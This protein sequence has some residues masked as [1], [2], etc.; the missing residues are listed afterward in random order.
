[1]EQ[2]SIM[3]AIKQVCA[4]KGLSVNDVMQTIETA[5]AAAYR[6]D[7]GN[8]MQNLKVEFNAETGA[9][10]VYDIKTVV[11]D[12]PEE[13][14]TEEG[15]ETQDVASKKD[16]IKE[17]SKDEEEVRRFNPKTEIQI[18]DAKKI[19]PDAEIGE[20]IITELEIPADY[21]RMAAQT[22]KQVI[23]QK[24]R[25]A[26][27]TKL[28]EEY[29]DKEG[30]II[31]GV[32]QRREPK[33]VLIDLGKAT[34][35]LPRE[36][37]IRI[38]QYIPGEHLKVFVKS[39]S[40]TLKGPEIIVSRS[41][42]NMVKE[43]FTLE[44]PEI[45]AGTVEIKS[46]ARE[47]GFRSKVAVFATDDTIDPIGSCVGQRGAR[48]QT[49]ISELGGEKI[50]IIEYDE[51]PGVFIANALSPAKVASIEVN[52]KEKTAIATVKEDQFS[53]A[54]GK[55]GQNVRLAAKLTDWKINIVGDDGSVAA[56]ANPEEEN[57][58]TE[59]DSEKNKDSAEEKKETGNKKL[60]TVDDDAKKKVDDKNK[61][62]AEDKE[63]K[64]ET[65]QKPHEIPHEKKEDKKDDKKEKGDKK[66]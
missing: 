41:H 48:I 64:K 38:E 39:V 63:D 28:F 11:E 15:A 32:V 25:E 7:F 16:E 52:E 12:M 40:T 8:K 47:A 51:D 3:S 1:M 58:A 20:E 22:A 27:R 54:I 29:R 6:K 21:G 10:K 56:E 55:E 50:D 5:L 65:K 33:R 53:L 4:E 18:S 23:I 66:K 37:Q 57:T 42:P 62:A 43:L 13:E 59:K 61:N 19:K 45:A 30:T 49:I 24:L 14:E 34:A 17:E 2:L 26:E 36:E 31:S 60:E 35:I 9:S 44:I 46:I